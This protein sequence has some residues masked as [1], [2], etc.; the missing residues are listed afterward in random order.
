MRTRYFEATQAEQGGFNWGKFTVSVLEGVDWSVRSSIS[1]E[2]VPLLAWR[3]WSPQH[4]IVF[5]LETGEGARFRHGGCARADLNKTGIWV[6][7]LF[8]AFLTWVYAQDLA[9]FESWPSTVILPGVE[10]DFSGFR[11]GGPDESERERV[12]AACR[13]RAADPS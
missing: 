11:R 3:G 7:V 2:P 12:R 4:I 13:V 8:E 10:A 9:Q 1:H 5:D 6:C